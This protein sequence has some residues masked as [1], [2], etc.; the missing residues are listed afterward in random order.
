MQIAQMSARFSLADVARLSSLSYSTPV[1]NNLEE[2][3]AL[4]D[5]VAP[6]ALGERAAFRRDF[7]A[8]IE[9]GRDAAASAATKRAGAERS[10]QLAALTERWML[11]RT[12]D[13]NTQ[14]VHTCTHLHTFA[15]LHIHV[16]VRFS[17]SLCSP[18]LRRHLPPR[19]E[20]VVFC[21]PSPL[22]ATLYNALL[23]LPEMRA[24]LTGGKDGSASASSGKDACA[25]LPPLVAITLLRRLCTS[26]G[27]ALRA[28]AAAG[29]GASAEEK[30]AAAAASGAGGAGGGATTE[31]P[32]ARVLRA[33]RA[34]LP[35]GTDSDDVAHSGKMA[36]TRPHSHIPHHLRF[37][38]LFLSPLRTHSAVCHPASRGCIRRR[39]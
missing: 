35:P 21:S 11:R 22:Q 26:P 20:Y 23:A 13:V 24:T 33:L 25:P 15:H 27:E 8:P 3:Y 18:P 17:R 12:A 7:C 2:F 34:L 16:L 4:L 19:Q 32:A 14:C 28:E 9:A 5:F 30:A 36:G 1:Q 37:F 29:A 38:S 10:A 39:G 31:T 6:G